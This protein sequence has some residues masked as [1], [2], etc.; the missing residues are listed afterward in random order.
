MVAKLAKN[1]G[2]LIYLV[3]KGYVSGLD[4]NEIWQALGWDELTEDEI[5]NALKENASLFD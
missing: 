3:R 4:L 1:R 5:S 2:L